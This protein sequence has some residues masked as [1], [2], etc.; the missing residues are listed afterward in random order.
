MKTSWTLGLDE[1]QAKEIRSDFKGS[2]L[3]RKRL[4]DLLSDKSSVS[5]RSTRSKELYASPSW[6]YMQADAVGYERALNE[7]ISLI[8]D[9]SV[10]K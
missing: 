10:E 6:A 5:A 9:D 1:Q 3:L 2:F 4:I 8:S 7:V